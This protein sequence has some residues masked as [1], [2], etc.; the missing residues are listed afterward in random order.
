MRTL[1][2]CALLFGAGCYSY[3]LRKPAVTP[4]EAFG[5]VASDLA[6]VCV[7]RPHWIAWAVTAAVRDNGQLVGATRGDTYFCYLVRPGHH[8]IESETVDM[9]ERAELDAAPGRRYWLHQLVDNYIAVVRT[10]LAWV[11][12]PAARELIAKC[13]YR[14][15]SG[16]PGQERLPSGDPIASR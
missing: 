12:E 6:E 13:G 11:D 14:E 16:V 3:Q 2:L 10:R 5:P 7:M 15:L 4:L 9:T 1:L 8:Q